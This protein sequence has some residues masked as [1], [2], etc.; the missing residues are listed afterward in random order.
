MLDCLSGAGG[1][2]RHEL[3]QSPQPPGPTS[4]PAVGKIAFALTGRAVP[5]VPYR[6]LGH[7]G[8]CHL[9][10]HGPAEIHGRTGRIRAV[11]IGGEAIEHV[12][13]DLETARPD[14]RT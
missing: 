7:S 2:R 13:P 14:A 3:D 6:R 12:T 9:D 4:V 10:A 8:R 5:Q 11:A 1:P